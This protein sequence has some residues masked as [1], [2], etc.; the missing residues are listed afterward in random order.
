MSA[1]TASGRVRKTP[2][3]SLKAIP[4]RLVDSVLAN[5]RTPSL[6]ARLESMAEE[7]KLFPASATWHLDETS[8]FEALYLRQYRPLVPATWDTQLRGVPI[9]EFC[10]SRNLTDNGRFGA[11]P[12]YST[13]D[14]E[15]RA[16]KA[17]MDL[18]DLTTNIRALRH[19]GQHAVIAGYLK[20][21][22]DKYLMWAAKDGE[23]YDVQAVPNIFCEILDTTLSV[24]GLATYVTN[25]MLHMAKQHRQFW[26]QRRCKTVSGKTITADCPVVYGLFV[27]NHTALVLTVDPNRG[28]NTP[29]SYQIEIDFSQRSQGI[30][31]ALTLG[32][33]SCMA[34]DG[35]VARDEF[36]RVRR[37]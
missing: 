17:F 32:I 33:T 9:P 5:Q 28:K 15:Y 3:K 37:R 27:L 11:P 8:L 19:L 31:N 12:I 1:R 21:E 23:Y 26:R 24:E 35:I 34:R 36:I 22:I 25:K 30:W 16:S 6:K 4:E 10:F 18:I 13:Q 2:R 14:T 7:K 29:V 20:D